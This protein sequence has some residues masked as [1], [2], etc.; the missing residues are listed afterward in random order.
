MN[1]G[2]AYRPGRCLGS[3]NGRPAGAVLIPPSPVQGR[4]ERVASHQ[5]RAT[6]WATA[7]AAV[8]LTFI[9]PAAHAVTPL[10]TL[11][12]CPDITVNFGGTT[13][14]PQNVAQDNLAGAVSLV[15]V[16]SIPFGTDVTAYDLLPNGEQLL[17]FDTT[18]S[19][20]G[21]VTARPGDV[22][23]FNGATY[24]LAFD[25]TAA[26]VPIGVMTDA[27]AVGGAADLLLSFDTTVTL[28]AVTANKEDLVFFDGANFSMFFDASAAGVPAGVDLDAFEY[29]DANGHL[30]LS[31][32]TS[33]SVGGVA[34]DKE[35][36]LEFDGAGAWQMAYDGSAQHAEWPPANLVALGAG[37]PQT[38]PPPPPPA[39]LDSDGD[40]VPNGSDNCPAV[41]NPDQQ[42]S[43]DD[44]VG[45]ACDNC[46][47]LFNAFQTPLC[48][49]PPATPALTLKRARLR[50]TPNG[51]IRIT[52]F[53]DTTAYGGLDGFVAALR[54]VPQNA[55][56]ALIRAGNAFVINLSGTGLLV[57]GQ[58]MMFPPCR[59]VAVCDGT[60]GEAARFERRGA[61]NVFRMTLEARGKSFAPPLSGSPL[62]VTLSL[63]GSDQPASASCRTGVRKQL[64]TCRP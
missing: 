29:L 24:T 19:L 15:N 46:V 5:P 6:P 48:T 17:A 31:F 32:D 25:A 26:G 14:T 18:V 30:R 49:A 39:P 1:C 7:V 22:V 42:D 33:G 8:F 21:G 44:G 16:G 59:A 40:G 60:A 61:T 54:T 12:F 9:A 23:R 20:P 37:I 62:T 28:G 35:D 43:D 52:G 38:V 64:A 41:R 63:G 58:T 47:S 34:F 56:S 13:V 36:V 11:R 3:P 50:T 45:N 4:P 53:L 57:P 10:N 51:T 27:V 2:Y 55:P